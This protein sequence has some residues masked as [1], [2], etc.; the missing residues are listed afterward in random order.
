MFA[1]VLLVC[2]CPSFS[3]PSLL[4]VRRPSSSRV[5]FTLPRQN[6]STT[7]AALSLALSEHSLTEVLCFVRHV[8]ELIRFLEA[9]YWYVTDVRWKS[10]VCVCVCVYVWY[11]C[12]GGCGCR[13][14][15]MYM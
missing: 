2:V 15:C 14:G 9:E 5:P 11:L 12:V 4:L 13:C 10:C 8:T 1:G 3:I 7:A 6:E